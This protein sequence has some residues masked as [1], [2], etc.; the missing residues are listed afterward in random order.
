M[1]NVL[2]EIIEGVRADEAARRM[3]DSELNRLIGETSSPLDALKSLRS[4]KFS[5]I[6]EVKRSSPS[7]GVLADISDPAE[8]ASTY[9]KNGAA[10]VSVLTEARRFNG[11]IEDL[12]KV[13]AAIDRESRAIGADVVLLIVAA[14]DDVQLLDYYQ[15]AGEL[16]MSVLVEIHDRTELERALSIQPKIIGVN[17]RNLKSLAVSNETFADLIPLIPSAIYR[18]AES[19]ISDLAAA[20]FARDCGADAI[21]VGEGLVRSAD[22]ATILRDFLSVN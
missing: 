19:G 4:R 17:S 14:L 6:A 22:P 11:S 13:R 7:K 15:L 16:G 10:V 21:L 8:L 20:K 1:T 5:V 9:R 18:V 3:T 2:A 12:R